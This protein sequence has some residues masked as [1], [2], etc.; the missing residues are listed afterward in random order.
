MKSFDMNTVLL[1]GIAIFLAISLGNIFLANVKSGATKAWYNM[2]VK[3]AGSKMGNALRQG[4]FVLLGRN[5]QGYQA[6][7]VVELSAST[8]ATLIANGGAVTNAGPATAGALT[9]NLPQGAGAFAIG[10]SST[11]I[12]N[13]LVTPQSIVFACINQAAADATLLR[14][15]RVVC[16]AGLFTVYGTANATAI[17]GFDWAIVN[18]GT[19]SNPT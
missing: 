4:G 9:G 2:T 5:Y 15:E 11:V 18:P 17:T 6:G 1:I 8:E 3:E 13:N 16:A 10:T 12:T 19:S 7:Q 14:I